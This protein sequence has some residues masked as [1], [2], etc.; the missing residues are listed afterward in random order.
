MGQPQLHEV[1]ARDQAVLRK[2]LPLP[3]GWQASQESSAA[4]RTLEGLHGAGNAHGPRSGPHG[5][6]G[7]VC[8]PKRV[9][10]QEAEGHAGSGRREVPG[11]GRRSRRPP[12]GARN[13]VQ[14][15][16]VRRVQAR[17]GA[18]PPAAP[19]GSP[20]RHQEGHASRAAR[21]GREGDPPRA[22][23]RHRA[24]AHQVHGDNRR[25]EALR[26]VQEPG[27]TR[28]PADPDQLPP[29][30]GRD[31]S[32]LHGLPQP[33][34]PPLKPALPCL[35]PP[36]PESLQISSSTASS[37]A[38][39]DTEAWPVYA[40]GRT[41][42]GPPGP[43]GSPPGFWP[44]SPPGTGPPRPRPRPPRRRPGRGRGRLGCGRGRGR[45]GRRGGRRRRAGTRGRRRRSWRRRT[46]SAWGCR[47]RSWGG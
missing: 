42:G 6:D 13:G 43:S 31:G 40:A 10:R 36:A 44:G 27:R 28:V 47:C 22:A 16:F 7:D 2:R 3:P 38:C 30:H 41:R 14:P 23:H 46:C 20:V 29:H 8:G 24:Q 9:R 26:A 1:R 21:Q 32:H 12:E 35:A 39:P 18:R 45:G 37:G 33:A 17:A 15:R 25:G 34:V 4:R 19:S 11:H 5:D